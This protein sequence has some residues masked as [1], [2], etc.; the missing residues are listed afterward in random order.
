[1]VIPK[2]QGLRVLPRFRRTGGRRERGQS[3]VELSLLLPLLLI[4]VLGAIDFGRVYFSYVTVTNGARTGA[5]YAAVRPANAIDTAGIE[6]AVLEETS[7]LSST[8]TVSSTTGSDGDGNLY[9]KVTVRHNFS[10]IFQWPG[11]P[12]SISM[13]RSVQM[14]VGP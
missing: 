1:M 5:E 6:A 11:I 3:L 8:P 13:E 12:D 10:P 14:R 9:A 7:S 2:L 4:L